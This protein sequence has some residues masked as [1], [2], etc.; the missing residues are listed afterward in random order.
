MIVF[1]LFFVDY[2]TYDSGGLKRLLRDSLTVA[3]VN[4]YIWIFSQ[5][6]H[7]WKV[8]WC[9]GQHVD[10]QIL[11]FQGLL[12]VKRE[13]HAV[14]EISY[15]AFIEPK[16]LAADVSEA[17]NYPTLELLLLSCDKSL[18]F[19]IHAYSLLWIIAFHG[20]RILLQ[21]YNRN[22]VPQLFLKHLAALPSVAHN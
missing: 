11:V 6:A 13:A 3:H 1:G 8:I 18:I 12:F 20:Y 5:V 21:W 19:E 22:R 7:K 15:S 16:V 14:F 17:L 4:K 10:L 9:Y 2:F